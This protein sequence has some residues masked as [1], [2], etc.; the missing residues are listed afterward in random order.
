MVATQ[1]VGL[2]LLAAAAM[3]GPRE[4]LDHLLRTLAPS[5]TPQTG[6]M[7]AHDKTWEQWQKRTG[8][9]PPDFSRL[10]SQ[11][12]L[13]DPL[14]GVTRATWAERRRR[15]RADFEKWVFGRM[16]PAPDNLTAEVVR[17]DKTG[18]GLRIR[19]V[20]LRFG[21]ERK[22]TLRVQL[23]IPPGPGPHP[24]FLT[25]HM[26]N[27]P[28]AATAVRR[29]YIGAIYYAADPIYGLTD[30]SDAWIEIYPEYDWSCLARWA[31]AA[32]RAVDYL[33]SLPEVDKGRI[34][35]TGHSRNGKQALLAAAFDERIA[36]VALSS[37]NTGEG[38][39][40]RY[41][42]P[43]FHNESIEQITGN[44]AHWFHPRLRFFAGREHK[45]PVD[46]NSLMALVAPRGLLMAS[47][48]GEAQGAP[49]GFE[50][51]YRSV[52]KVY[53]FLEVPNRLGLS[54]RAG[55]HATTAEDIEQY[56]DF[57]D[58]VFLRRAGKP[59]ETFVLGYRYADWLL[60]TGEK[61]PRA[62]PGTPSQRL[63][64]MLGQ[65]PAAVPFPA[66]SSLTPAVRTSEG[67]MAE[68]Y[69]RPLTVPG[70]KAWPLAFGD[71]LK[72]DLYLPEKRTGPVPVVLYLHGLS[73]AT[74]Y[75]RDIRWTIGEL[76]RRGFAVAAWDHAGFGSRLFSAREFYARYPGWSLMGKMEADTRAAVEAVA[77]LAEIDAANIY[78]LGNNLGSRVALYAAMGTERVKALALLGGVG[79]LH[80]DGE[81]LRHFSHLHG[82]MPRLGD[83][84]PA[85][86]VELMQACGLPVVWVG[87]THDRFF[88]AG[89]APGNVVLRTTEDF[90]GFTRR[91]QELAFEYLSAWASPQKLVR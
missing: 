54:L 46:Q 16:P 22:A 32:H 91:A 53:E 6:R 48:Y 68:M 44:F 26:R 82:L 74:G 43:V 21:P 47:A 9:L 45:L 37:G 3:A 61:R 20:V 36:A 55:E 7:N 8:E 25:N 56:V 27:R 77:A 81:G 64:W 41:T 57:F 35:I 29:G 39:P 31:W 70:A 73:Y 5:R 66:A 12:F 58:T 72:A 59:P 40:W 90:H 28:W 42:H 79:N 23:L 83:A 2:F 14:E 13:P 1:A 34:A 62:V 69:G 89:N 50:Q 10:A 17:E 52:K 76:V 78:L 4:D 84:M 38:N 63:R 65:E 33:L 67:W 86:D 15:I 60:K 18:E 51:A 30:D 11:P 71:D 49:F 87:P 88:D 19:D 75:S 80:P 85:A 24:V